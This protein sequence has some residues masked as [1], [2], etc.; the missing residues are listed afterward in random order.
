MQISLKEFASFSIVTLASFSDGTDY[1]ETFCKLK[2][3]CFKMYHH[4]L[5]TSTVHGIDF[6]QNVVDFI[7]RPKDW[8]L[9]FD[10]KSEYEKNFVRILELNS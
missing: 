9:Q 5:I 4:G 8:L 3:D 1:A 10:S 6:F 2:H 7:D